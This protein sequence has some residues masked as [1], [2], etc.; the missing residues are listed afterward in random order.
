ML[1]PAIRPALVRMARLRWDEQ[2]GSDMLIAPERGLL[3]D[4]VAAQI[5]KLCDGSR[6]VGEILDVLAAQYE[7]AGSDVASDLE[8]FLLELAR[9]GLM[10]L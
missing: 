8:C 1:D 5:V 9:R 4:A 3:L 7:G 2:M 6:T 10:K